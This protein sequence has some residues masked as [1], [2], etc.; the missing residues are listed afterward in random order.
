MSTKSRW[1]RPVSHSDRRLLAESPSAIAGLSASQ[2]KAEQA[3]RLYGAPV[4]LRMQIGS[5][6]AAWDVAAYERDVEVVRSALPPDVFDVAWEAGAALPVPAVIAEAMACT[7]PTTEPDEAGPIAGLT[8]READVLRQLVEG[9]P[10]REIVQ[11][12]SISPRTVGGYVSELLGKLGVES[13][14]AAAAPAVCHGL[15]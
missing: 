8:A 11:A 7:L 5:G 1:S 12:L 3:A 4:A 13:R 2:G 6:T 10:D 14:T 9:R 15:V